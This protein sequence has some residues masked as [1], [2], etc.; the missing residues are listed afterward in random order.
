MDKF[1]E[2]T[3]RRAASLHLR[4]YLRSRRRLRSGNAEVHAAGLHRHPDAAQVGQAGENR[5]TSLRPRRLRCRRR[6]R[7]LARDADRHARGRGRLSQRVGGRRGFPARQA[8]RGAIPPGSGSG[9]GRQPRSWSAPA[10]RHAQL[11]QLGS[12]HGRR[13]LQRLT[14]DERQT[15]DRHRADECASSS[16][17][18][19]NPAH[20]PPCG[21]SAMPRDATHTACV[22]EV[23]TRRVRHL[24]DVART[25]RRFG[26]RT[27]VGRDDD[28]G[29]DAGPVRHRGRQPVGHAPATGLPS[30]RRRGCLDKEPIWALLW[31]SRDSG[32]WTCHP[33]L[34]QA[35]RPLRAI[36]TFDPALA[37][38]DLS[39]S[40]SVRHCAPPG[41]LFSALSRDSARLVP[42]YRRL[43]HR[44]MQQHGEVEKPLPGG[45]LVAHSLRTSGQDRGGFG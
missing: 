32:S 3:Q 34:S 18:S 29:G 26:V 20:S 42:G 25:R 21:S 22:L 4:P 16:T 5:H 2:S 45:E 23:S 43:L 7:F 36:G 15:R 11:R 8:D 41:S 19:K 39:S 24:S 31:T 10:V 9:S 14:R 38:A 35:I 40:P 33:P 13:R 27:L 44:D 28:G 17:V 37:A 6:R 12:G 1:A 30:D